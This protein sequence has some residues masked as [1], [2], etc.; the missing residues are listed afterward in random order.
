MAQAK[1]ALRLIIHI[2]VE[3]ALPQKSDYE[4]TYEA[5]AISA[6][7]C[8]FLRIPTDRFHF[9]LECSPKRSVELLML[10]GRTISDETLVK[11]VVKAGCVNGEGF[12]K[13]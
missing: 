10:K 6:P 3:W 8:I 1:H 12:W 9:V 7:K 13:E 5:D 11:F 4:P 2:M